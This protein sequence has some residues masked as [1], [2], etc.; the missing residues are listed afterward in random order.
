LTRTLGKYKICDNVIEENK[1]TDL[2]FGLH[3]NNTIHNVRTSP[4]DNLFSN[5]G[6]SLA[7]RDRKIHY[8]AFLL[9]LK[10][11]IGNVAWKG[12]KVV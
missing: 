7:W 5:T 10:F 11:Y 9:A 12:Y 1:F 4:K 8:S 3:K 2:Y 6:Q